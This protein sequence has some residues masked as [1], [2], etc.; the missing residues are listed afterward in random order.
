MVFF[1]RLSL[2]PLS[3]ALF[4]LCSIKFL[5]YRPKIITVDIHRQQLV[6]IVHRTIIAHIIGTLQFSYYSSTQYLA[7]Y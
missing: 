7:S 4:I 5:S 6:N 2:L 3:A 1:Y